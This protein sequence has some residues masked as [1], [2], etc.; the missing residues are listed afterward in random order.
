[1]KRLNAAASEGR[2]ASTALPSQ[3]FAGSSVAQIVLTD[4]DPLLRSYEVEERPL[5]LHTMNF[6]SIERM[7]V[8]YS[9]DLSSNLRANEVLPEPLLSDIRRSKRRL[10]TIRLWPFGPLLRAAVTSELLLHDGDKNTDPQD[11]I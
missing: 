10:M 3:S 5:E 2:K 9:Q 11:V 1:M 4:A 8:K 6:G 7:E